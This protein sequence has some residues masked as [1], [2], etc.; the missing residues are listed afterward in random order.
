[1]TYL[2]I[3][4]SVI[5]SNHEF[6]NSNFYLVKQSL[7]NLLG[8][9]EIMILGLLVRVRGLRVEEKHQKLYKRLG[10][11]TEQFKV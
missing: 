2:G 9:L 11:L 5:E 10:K 8:I 4:E 1:M 7:H 3:I 6:A